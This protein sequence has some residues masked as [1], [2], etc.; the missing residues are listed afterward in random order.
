MHLPLLTQEI[1]IKAIRDFFRGKPFVFFGTG[2]SCAMDFGF[3]MPALRDELVK[4][5]QERALTATQASEWQR[6]ANALEQGA[7]LRVL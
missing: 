4:R 6:A 7:I 1:A 3:G 2:M 5:M